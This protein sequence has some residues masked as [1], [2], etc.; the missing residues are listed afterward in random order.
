MTKEIND[1]LKEQEEVRQSKGIHIEPYNSLNEEVSRLTMDMERGIWQQEV[2]EAKGMSEVLEAK[3]MSEVLE[4]K[5]M[6]EV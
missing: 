6:S 2:L 1:K 4:A 5:G 3:G